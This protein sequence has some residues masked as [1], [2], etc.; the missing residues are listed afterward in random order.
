M[1]RAA[2]QT[3]PLFTCKLV[4]KV[5]PFVKVPAVTQ[6]VYNVE[7]FVNYENKGAIFAVVILYIFKITSTETG[8]II[9][10]AV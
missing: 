7:R 3:K 6:H 4:L 10:C 9:K 5:Q 2:E 1:K 8:T